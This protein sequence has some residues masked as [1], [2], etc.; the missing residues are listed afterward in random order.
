VLLSFCN[1]RFFNKNQNYDNKAMQHDAENPL[2]PFSLKEK[3]LRET[4]QIEQF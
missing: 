3:I 2:K 4:R 1:L